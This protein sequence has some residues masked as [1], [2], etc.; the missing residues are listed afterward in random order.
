MYGAATQYRK[1]AYLRKNGVQTE[2]TVIELEADKS[3]KS[4]SLYPVVRFTTLTRKTVTLRYNFGSYPAAFQ[5]GQRVQI[6]YD[7]LA[8]EKFV[9]GVGDTDWRTVVIALMGLFFLGLGVYSGLKHY[10]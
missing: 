4:R 8:P 9:I 7:P 6:L 3:P 10:R 5:P 2:G 1:R